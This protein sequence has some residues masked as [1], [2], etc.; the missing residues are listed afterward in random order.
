MQML[1]N[2]FTSLFHLSIDCTRCY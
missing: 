2:S 1:L